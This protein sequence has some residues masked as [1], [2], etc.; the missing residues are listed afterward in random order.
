MSS[1]HCGDR[2][3]VCTLHVLPPLYDML[4]L[5]H[6]GFLTGDDG[7]PSCRCL[8][9]DMMA[10][11]GAVMI[12]WVFWWRG[13]WLTCTLWL[14]FAWYTFGALLN[15]CRVVGTVVVS[16]STAVGGTEE[17]S[18][19]SLAL[20]DYD[21]LIDIIHDSTKCLSITSSYRWRKIW[22]FN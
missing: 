21:N 13:D 16:G 9:V 20:Q 22:S 5:I 12:G 18:C 8:P 11:R 3:I 2:L 19:L 17:S 10:I 1:V 14:Y 15:V 6:R 4:Q 7:Q